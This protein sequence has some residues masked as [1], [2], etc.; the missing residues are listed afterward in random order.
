MAKPSGG[1][2]RVQ[3][4]GMYLLTCKRGKALKLKHNAPIFLYNNSTIMWL[5]PPHI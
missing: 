2:P 4:R 1:G 5:K 3:P